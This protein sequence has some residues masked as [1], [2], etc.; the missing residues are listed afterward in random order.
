MSII[1]VSENKYRIFVSDGSKLN[2]NRKRYSKTISTDL[3]GRDLERFLTLAEYDFEDEIKNKDSSFIEL[4]NGTFEQYTNWWL[5]YKKIAPKTLQEYKFLLDSRILPN[6]KHKKFGR[7]T[8]GDMI[9]L[10][11]II[12]H[13]P[14]KTKSG[15]LSLKSIKHYHTILKNMFN[16]AVKLKIISEN[17]MLNVPVKSPKAKLKENYYDLDDVNKLLEV[18]EGS[19]TKFHLCIM[20]ALTTGARLG[21]ITGLQW[22]HIDLVNYQIK[23]EQA[24]SFI[25]GEGSVI[26]STKNESSERT[27]A[28]PRSLLE[29]FSKHEKDELEKKEL[30][31]HLWHYQDSDHKDDFV[32]TKDTGEIMFVSTPSAWFQKLIKRKGLKH[33]TFHGLRHTNTTILIH[34]GINIV[35][36]SNSLGHSKTSTT[37]DYYAH[38]LTSVER[39]MANTFDEII[40]ENENN[41]STGSRTGSQ[42]DKIRIIK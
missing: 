1:K 23:I 6:I 42:D 10:M 8:T 11:N 29:L 3:K 28:F 4:S 14:A 30:L 38:H 12:E 32:F 17:P 31:D 9:E 40:I 5:K 41:I 16:D 37:T 39:T 34:S 7:L 21:E 13:S 18:L 26:K 2:G 25:S 27:V 35:S 20:I 33:I 22:K 36:I 15:K 19:P 24:N